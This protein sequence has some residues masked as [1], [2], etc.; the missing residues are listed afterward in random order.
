MSVISRRDNTIEFMFV[1]GNF[2]VVWNHVEI[3][4]R[5]ILV[6]LTGG[7]LAATVI[8]YQVG[9]VSLTDA[10]R[11]SSDWHPEIKDHL[12]HFA[13]NMDVIRAYRNYYVHN[14]IGMGNDTSSGDVV[15]I[16]MALETKGKYRLTEKALRVPDLERISALA[17]DLRKYGIALEDVLKSDDLGERLR[18][19]SS[20]EKPTRPESLAK[21]VHDPRSP[22]PRPQSSPE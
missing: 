11:V 21:H 19:S 3:A 13:T 2:I 8:S 10:M 12:I 16:V 20:L 7:N 4:A 6:R 14:L 17:D 18:L 15:G 9:N 1:F 5:N 22:T